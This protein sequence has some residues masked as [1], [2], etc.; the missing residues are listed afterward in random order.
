MSFL[1]QR[2]GLA[3]F[4]A[5]EYY[6]Q[7]LQDYQKGKL[8]EALDNVGF[9]LTLI[10]QNSEYLAAQGLFYLED[11]VEDKARES[12]QAALTLHDAEAA[13][14]YGMGVLAFNDKAWDEAKVYFNKVVAIRPA[15][16][17]IPYY[18]ALIYHRQQDNHTA[19]AYMEQALQQ[20]EDA[21]DKRRT[22]ARRWVREFD[23]LITQLE[24]AEDEET[25]PPQQ[26][27]F[28]QKAQLEQ[29]EA[30]QL[31]AAA[32]SGALEAGDGPADAA[33]DEA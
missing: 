6:A 23:K 13:A 2:L 12:F 29:A 31:T 22:S 1:T 19:K 28:Y 20:M 9:A 7:A 18:M 14:N 33:D 32:H 30:E 26:L 16:I 21:G 27:S 11:G 3:R 17:E 10:P 25:L 4:E 24:R 15:Q 5:D 8:Q